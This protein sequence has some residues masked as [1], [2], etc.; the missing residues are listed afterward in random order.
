M[1]TTDREML[2]QE[3]AAFEAAMLSE[4]YEEPG[5]PY[6]DGSYRQSYYSAGWAMWLASMA[7]HKP[8]PKSALVLELY[9]EQQAEAL[10]VLKRHGQRAVCA[11]PHCDCN[12]PTDDCGRQR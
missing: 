5:L 2:A 9:S 10:M 4:G 8:D 7:R 12:D 3:K 6:T 11:Y 1:S